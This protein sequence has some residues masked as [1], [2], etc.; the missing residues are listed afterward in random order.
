MSD[1]Q[2]EKVHIVFSNKEDRVKDTSYEQYIISQNQ[3]LHEENRQLTKHLLELESL[4]EE[5]ESDNSNADKRINLMKGLL[6]NFHE[7][8]KMRKSQYILSRDLTSISRTTFHRY[9]EN[10]DGVI[11]STYVFSFLSLILYYY[12][13]DLYKFFAVFVY[14]F[15]ICCILGSRG[16]IL[17]CTKHIEKEIASIQHTIDETTKGQDYIHEFLD[18]C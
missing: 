13:F 12:Y 15:F 10:I 17:P 11:A 16:I 14:V 6:K 7:M 4:I 18:S 5:H 9:K 8:N 1:Q 2:Q 3:S